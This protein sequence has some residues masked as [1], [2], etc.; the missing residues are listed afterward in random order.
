MGTERRS[1]E[2]GDSRAD[3]WQVI[4]AAGLWVGGFALLGFLQIVTTH[5][6]CS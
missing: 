1:R 5:Y 4:K 3:E 2:P 6:A